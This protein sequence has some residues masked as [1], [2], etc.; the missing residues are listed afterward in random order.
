ML[1]DWYIQTKLKADEKKDLKDFTRSSLF[2][3]VNDRVK[4]DSQPDTYWRFIGQIFLSNLALLKFLD[5]QQLRNAKKLT[6]A[7]IEITF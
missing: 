6:S 7:V 3:N 2:V 4:L 1:G 5:I